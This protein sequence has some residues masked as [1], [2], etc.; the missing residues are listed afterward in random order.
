M[1]KLLMTLARGAAAAAEEDVQD[2]HALLIL[3]QQMR[4]VASSVDAS[5]RALAIA[6]AQDEAEVRRVEKIAAR[7]AD[8]EERALAAL[9][10]GREDLAAEAAE[11][12]AALEADRAAIDEARQ[13]FGA[14]TARLKRA[15]ADAARRLAELERGR[16]VAHAAEA[17]RRLRAGR[18][19]P[20]SSSRAVLAEAEAT[21][22][23]LRE[24]QAEDAAAVDAL[25]DFDT[26][27]GSASIADRLEA[28][29]F[30][31]RTRPT[32]SEVLERLK[33]KASAAAPSA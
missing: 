19:R 22:K 30:G 31:P 21:L 10:G 5:K 29:G 8:L 16:R 32:A 3:D 23:R 14:E 18:L 15:V 4:D 13:S 25:D 6:I 27:T 7:I 1:L 17:V 26:A 28:A 9:G 33:R 11:A 12:I 2:R 24:K 20:G